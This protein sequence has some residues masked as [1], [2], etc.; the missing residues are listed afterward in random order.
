MSPSVLPV[1]DGLLARFRAA[2]PRIA[3][4]PA[5]SAKG[6]RARIAHLH[7]EEARLETWGSD[8][9]GGAEVDAG[10][11]GALL[12]L[13]EADRRGVLPHLASR[14]AGAD[15]GFPQGA[16]RARWGR[17]PSRPEPGPTLRD[18]TDLARYALA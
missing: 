16:I 9:N 18:L 3:W 10:P 1:D 12:L 5:R 17:G 2:A 11:L 7:D 8:S 6:R 15:K 14:E 4:R 13:L